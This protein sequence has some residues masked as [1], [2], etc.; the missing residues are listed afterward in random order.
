MHT[1]IDPLHVHLEVT[2]TR[3]QDCRGVQLVL[4]H[5]L[6]LFSGAAAIS[7]CA[8]S[9]S[10]AIMTSATDAR[11]FVEAH[12]TG[13]PLTAWTALAHISSLFGP[14]RLQVPVRCDSPDATTHAMWVSAASDTWTAPRAAP[15]IVCAA[16]LLPAI[17]TCRSRGTP[18]RFA[19]WILAFRCE[20]GEVHGNA[21]LLDREKRLL[22]RFEPRGARTRSRTNY[23]APILDALLTEFARTELC[24]PA[25]YLA[26]REYQVEVGNQTTEVLQSPLGEETLPRAGPCVAWSLLFIHSVLL[27]PDVPLARVVAQLARAHTAQTLIIE[28]Y[29]HYL[30]THAATCA[31]R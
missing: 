20:D 27:F 26:P 24:P 31:S 5:C 28:M 10:K 14:S 17:N 1:S 11:P 29:A 16:P 7:S 13:T 9:R 4:S 18:A 22:V 6:A 3:C 23:D 15:R 8:G 2:V 21:M 19:A 30:A 25:T 12:F